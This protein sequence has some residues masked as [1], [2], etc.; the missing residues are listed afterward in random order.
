M[1]EEWRHSSTHSEPRC[2][3]EAS[4]QP[5][6]PAALPPPPQPG[7]GFPVP[8]D[9]DVLWAPESV[10]TFW[11][12][13]Q[14]LASIGN[15]TRD[16]PACRI[17]VVLAMLSRFQIFFYVGGGELAISLLEILD[18]AIHNIAAWT[19]RHLGFVHSCRG[20][21]VIL[22]YLFLCSDRIIAAITRIYSSRIL[23]S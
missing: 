11:R 20:F 10:R 17:V 2:C 12:R 14:F 15:R 3:I 4:G 16:R 22:R 6:A 23:L 7:K 18:P 9:Q 19:A 8:I 21:L 5:E 13:D 1:C